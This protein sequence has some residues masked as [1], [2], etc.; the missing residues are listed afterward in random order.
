MKT[1]AQFL[2]AVLLLLAIV[3]AITGCGQVCTG[4]AEEIARCMV[5][6]GW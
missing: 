3:A 1:F 2:A 5:T 4:D 6:V